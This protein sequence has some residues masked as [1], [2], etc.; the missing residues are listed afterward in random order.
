MFVC[1]IF[2]FFVKK[3]YSPQVRSWGVYSTLNVLDKSFKP[4]NVGATSAPEGGYED[5]GIIAKDVKIEKTDVCL[6]AYR[7][8]IEFQGSYINTSESNYFCENNYY[9]I[10]NGSKWENFN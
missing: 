4:T 5:K 9:F 10:Q 2:N 8:K 1:S 3:C 7:N 6:I